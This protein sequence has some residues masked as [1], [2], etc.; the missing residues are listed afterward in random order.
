MKKYIVLG[1]VAGTAI[2]LFLMLWRR[3]ELEGTE[4]EELYDSSSS[5]KNL[6]G[7]AFEELP[8]KL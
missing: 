6:F 5:P 8:D 4:F 7:K 1:L 3:K 2:S